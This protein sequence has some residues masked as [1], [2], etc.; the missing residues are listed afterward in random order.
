MHG[1]SGGGV[2]LAWALRWWATLV[3]ATGS[4]GQTV[5]GISDSSHGLSPL[6][7]NEQAPPKAPV[8]PGVTTEEGTTTEQHLLSS[9]PWEHTCLAVA[10]AKGSGHC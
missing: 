5:A 4:R 7:D 10:A 2:P 8:T 1:Y 6:G 3:W 9:L